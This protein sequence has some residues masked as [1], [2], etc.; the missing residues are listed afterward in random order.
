M[1]EI[2][3]DDDIVKG[4]GH[5]AASQRMPHVHGVTKQDQ[6]FSVIDGGWQPAVWHRA[7]IFRLKSFEEG[8][9]NR[10]GETR[11]DQILQVGLEGTRR[12]RG[13]LSRNVDEDSSVI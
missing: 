13:E 11:R 2:T 8:V 4:N 12:S 1:E 10:L 3:Q 5:T 7:Q 6:A 9:L